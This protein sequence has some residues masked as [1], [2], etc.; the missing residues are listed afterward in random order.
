M[1]PSTAAGKG[2]EAFWTV[3]CPVNVSDPF[4]R[5]GLLTGTGAVVSGLIGSCSLVYL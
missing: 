1:A 5:Y 2:S 3:P 4:A